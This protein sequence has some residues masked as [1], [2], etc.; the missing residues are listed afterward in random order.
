VARNGR[1][2]ANERFALF[3][4]EG[5]TIQEAAR[6]AGISERTGRRRMNDEAFL[7]RLNAIRSDMVSRA[8]GRLSDASSAAADALRGLLD[9]ESE[10][11][12]LG[13]CRAIIEL[14][15]R[16]RDSMEL[17]ERVRALELHDKKMR[18]TV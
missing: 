4:A 3:L 18:T 15:A 1:S 7:A 2:Q 16:L 14:G 12:R 13:A 5:R 17:E 8:L 10:S 9:A 11:V 6:L